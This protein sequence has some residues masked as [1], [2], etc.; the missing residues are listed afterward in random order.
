[1]NNTTGIRHIAVTNT[2]K[3][4]NW[5]NILNPKEYKAFDTQRTNLPIYKGHIDVK[6][7]YCL[8]SIRNYNFLSKV[9]C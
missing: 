9:I 2:T 5:S 8:S 1:M 4:Y 7:I 3:V 6:N